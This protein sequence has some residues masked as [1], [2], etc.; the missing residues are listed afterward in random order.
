MPLAGRPL[1]RIVS[2]VPVIDGEMTRTKHFRA[3]YAYTSQFLD[4]ATF[5][6]V[7]IVN[8]GA[9][10]DEQ[11]PS[12][13]GFVEGIL[14]SC[15]LPVTLGGG[16]TSVDHVAQCMDLGADRVL[17]G[18]A[19]IDTPELIEAV[20][21]RWG[22]QAVVAGVS[23][24]R[25]DGRLHAVRSRQPDMPAVAPTDLI[26]SLQDRGAGEVLINSVE[27][28]GALTGLDAEAVREMLPHLRVP[29]VVTGGIGNW[30]HLVQAIEDLGASGA[31]TS[32]IYH[33]TS[34]SVAAAKRYL[35]QRGIQVR[36]EHDGD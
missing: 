16:V 3:D 20:A 31:A 13:A 9:S 34:E 24:A 1:P 5:D 12:F 7:T 25:F 17:V 23:V 15:F 8:V 36:V 21:A 19:A 29:Y 30:K 18:S 22:S 2:L 4:L 27:R 10:F 28:D 14:R 35:L 33:L 11:L 6:E 32:N 26:R